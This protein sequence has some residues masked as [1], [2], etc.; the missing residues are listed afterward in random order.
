MIQFDKDKNRTVFVRRL[1]LMFLLAMP[2]SLVMAEGDTLAGDWDGSRKRLVEKGV[3]LNAGYPGNGNSHIIGDATGGTSGHH[4]APVAPG[5]DAGAIDSKEA[6]FRFS[7]LPDPM[8]QAG[9]AQGVTNIETPNK[10]QVHMAGYAQQFGDCFSTKP[11]INDLSGGFE[12]VVS[13][14]RFLD[15]A[16]GI[17][18][19]ISQTGPPLFLHRFPADFLEYSMNNGRYPQTA[20]MTQTQFP[21]DDTM[22]GIVHGKNTEE[23]S[24]LAGPSVG[25]GDEPND[26]TT[27]GVHSNI[28]QH[29]SLQG[30]ETLGRDKVA[31]SSLELLRLP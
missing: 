1:V 30:K 9:N 11:G 3:N 15:G 25:L 7:V 12:C 24:V 13:A 26:K 23:D 18:T 28:Y 16:H 6:D 21:P 4:Q 2:A 10:G 20:C 29:I 27:L 8:S 22:P 5:V 14:G 17:G 31:V 19:T